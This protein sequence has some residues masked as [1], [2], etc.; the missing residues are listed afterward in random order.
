MAASQP[1]SSPP[2]KSHFLRELITGVQPVDTITHQQRWGKR[3]PATDE[4]RRRDAG[5]PRLGLDVQQ[6]P[7]PKSSNGR[8]ASMVQ[9]FEAASLSSSRPYSPHPPA[10]SPQSIPLPPSPTKSR[11]SAQGPSG[12]SPSVPASFFQQQQARRMPPT[13]PSSGKENRA[14]LHPI[15][16]TSSASPDPPSPSTRSQFS[17]TKPRDRQSERASTSGPSSEVNVAGASNGSEVSYGSS[18]AGAASAAFSCEGAFVGHATVETVAVSKPSR[19]FVGAAPALGEGGLGGG[20]RVTERPQPARPR[21]QP[22]AAVLPPQLQSRGSS[23]IEALPASCP[24]QQSPPLVSVPFANLAPAP[25]EYRPQP[26]QQYPA[27]PV[28]KSYAPLPLDERVPPPVAKDVA[29]S[30]SRSATIGGERGATEKPQV[31]LRFES[32]RDKQSRIERQFEQLLVRLPFSSM[33]PPLD[34]N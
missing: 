7:P 3:P 1:P 16:R 31:D 5:A 9:G 18:S 4:P 32:L 13:S 21:P 22:Q 20:A 26:H 24:S 17:P 27:R 15:S 12:S 34:C 33:P 11:T 19:I 30:R 25:T 23:F 2:K 29:R 14:L 10:P 6:V 28:P 8:V